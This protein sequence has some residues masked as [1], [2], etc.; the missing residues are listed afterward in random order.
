MGKPTK[1]ISDSVTGTS[2]S[3]LITF[4]GGHATLN[5]VDHSIPAGA[6]HLTL[7]GGG[8][9]DTIVS[10]S[11]Y[12]SA[13][14]ALSFDGGTGTDTL[15]LSNVGEAVWVRLAAATRPGGSQPVIA[16]QFTVEYLNVSGGDPNDPNALVTSATDPHNNI[17]NIESVIGTAYN[18]YLELGNYSGTADGGAG[19]DRVVGGIG[20]DQ[21]FGGAG[22]DFLFGKGGDDVMTGGAGADQ[23][24]VITFNGNDVITDFNAAEGDTL[25]IGWQNSTDVI[26]DGNSWQSSSWTDSHGLVHQAITASFTGGSITLV[27]L[28][29]ADVPILMDHTSDFHFL[30]G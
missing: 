14:L 2:G 4:I 24:E 26:P 28:T 5:G 25:H 23:F 12:G 6:T 17:T 21:L 1:A 3:D 30:N 22:D 9:N 7:S 19:N 10:D 29:L 13:S 8:G 11:P 20:N 18:D 15:D 16:T 27:D